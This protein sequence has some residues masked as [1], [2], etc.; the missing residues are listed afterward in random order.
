MPGEMEQTGRISA[1]RLA[2]ICVE[3]VRLCAV[4]KHGLREDL[5]LPPHVALTGADHGFRKP[6]Y[7]MQAEEALFAWFDSHLR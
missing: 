3:Y 7:A 1:V 2:P 4:S 6:E 5:A